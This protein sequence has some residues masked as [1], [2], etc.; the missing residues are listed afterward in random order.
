MESKTRRRIRITTVT[1]RG[2][3][4]AYLPDPAGQHPTP[5]RSPVS[6]RFQP[7]DEEVPLEIITALAVGAGTLRLTFYELWNLSRLVGPARPGGPSILG[8]VKRQ[9]APRRHRPPQADQVRRRGSRAGPVFHGCCVT[10]I[11]EG[12]Q[13]NLSGQ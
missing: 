2:T 13:I 7:I 3:R 6:G 1:W 4:L 11:D 8:S 5:G 9:I 10:D 12:E